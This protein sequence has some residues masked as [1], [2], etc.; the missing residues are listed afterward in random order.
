MKFIQKHFLAST[1]RIKFALE[2]SEKG[3]EIMKKSVLLGV[4]G[5][6]LHMIRYLSIS[7]NIKKKVCYLRIFKYNFT[8]NI[9]VAHISRVSYTHVPF[10]RLCH[11]KVF[12]L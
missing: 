9:D 4:L 5:I 7:E 11:Y 1:I 10:K 6:K 2:D 8:N 12:K 3:F